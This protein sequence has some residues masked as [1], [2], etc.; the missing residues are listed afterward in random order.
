MRLALKNNTKI[1]LKSY[2]CVWIC[3]FVETSLM[4][5]LVVSAICKCVKLLDQ[6]VKP[7]IEMNEK[8]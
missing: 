6:Y 1:A 7:Q 5:L 4:K 8:L 2:V 3:S